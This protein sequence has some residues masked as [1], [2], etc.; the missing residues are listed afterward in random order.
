MY[1]RVC[2]KNGVKTHESMIHDVNNMP[3]IWHIEK[4]PCSAKKKRRRPID[5]KVFFLNN[6]PKRKKKHV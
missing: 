6:L 2:A 3:I 1:D 4:K 5:P